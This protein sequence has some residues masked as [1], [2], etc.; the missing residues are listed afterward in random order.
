MEIKDKAFVVTGG[1]SLIGSHIAEQLLGS[2]ARKVVLFDNFSL[3]TTD[4]VSEI[5]KDPR[6]ELFRGDLLRTNELYDAFSGCDGVFA[7]AGFLTLPMSQN[8]PLGLAVNVQG[9]ANLLEACRYASVK[10]VIFSS[11]IAAYGEPDADLVSED[12]PYHWQKFQPATALYGATKII[13]ENLGRLYEKKYG[14]QSISLRYSTVYGERQHYRG[15]NALYIIDSYDRIKRGERPVISGDGSEVHDYIHVA[16]AARAN[17]A[18]MASDVASDSFNVVTG[19]ATNL[20]RIVE[21]ILDVVGSDLKPEYSDGGALVRST[22]SEKLNLSNEKA[23]RLLG[24]RP[25]VSI[26]EGIARLI[27]WREA[28]DTA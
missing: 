12:E 27:R 3:G 9:H 18:A 23:A 6:V 5:L 24:W 17:L 4:L 20:N 7:A 10:K 19:E 13:G 15:V 14:I 26:E 25:E 28:T 16:D 1:V 11:S 21:I 22:A 8:P 2:G